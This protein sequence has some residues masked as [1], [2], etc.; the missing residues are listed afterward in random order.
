MKPPVKLLRT[1]ASNPLVEM[2]SIAVRY[3][4]PAL[5]TNPS[6]RPCSASTASMLAITWDS[7]R[8]SHAWMLHCPPSS[9][10]SRRTVS[11]FS[12]LRPQ[13]ATR[14]PSAASSCAVQRPMPLPPPVTMMAWPAKTPARKTDWYGM[15]LPSRSVLNCRA[16]D[17]LAGDDEFHDLRRAI[18]DLQPHNIAQALLVRQVLAPAVMAERQ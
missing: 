3:W 6:M 1:T 2:V 11:S 5:F 8:I 13:I 10:I 17:A 7:S 15:G 12:T 14:A 4:P 9:R 18:A 16:A